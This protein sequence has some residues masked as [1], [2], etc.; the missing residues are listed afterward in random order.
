M[1]VCFVLHCWDLPCSAG[2]QLA[3]RASRAAK[4]SPGLGGLQFKL[5]IGSHFFPVMV[6][7]HWSRLLR[8]V[9]RAPGLSVFK[10]DLD[11]VLNKVL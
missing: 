8:E 2:L 11:D 10:R 4:Q 5:D 7:K 9:V 3:V 1:W 6:V